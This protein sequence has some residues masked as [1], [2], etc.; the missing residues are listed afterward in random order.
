MSSIFGGG[1]GGGDVVGPASSTDNALAR[2]DGTTGKLIQNGVITQDDTGNLSVAAAVSAGSLS[3]LVSNTSNTTQAT[4]FIKAMV[5]GSTADDPYFQAGI[6]GGQFYSFGL[7]NSDSDAFVISA[8]QTIG[9]TN[10]MRISTAGEI[11]FPLQPAFSAFLPSNDDNVTGDGTG[12]TLGGTT[13][14][15]EIYDQN[16]DFN[17]NGTFTAPVTGKYMLGTSCLFQ[18]MGATNQVT[19]QILTSNRDYTLGN[20]NGEASIGNDPAAF[21]VLADM[22][23][24]DTSTAFYIVGN[25]TKTVDVYGGAADARSIFWGHLVC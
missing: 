5:A 21:S 11:T 18:G 4:V 9:T 2:F 6:S 14:L 16:S 25:G 20:T 19:I 15:T 17:T 12:Y 13:A 1:G 10:V 8:S 23:V 24:G 22:D 3:I 7:D